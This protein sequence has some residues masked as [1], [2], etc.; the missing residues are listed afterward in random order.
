MARVLRTLAT[1]HR[2][3]AQV[4]CSLLLATALPTLAVSG[5][6]PCGEQ[7]A[8][9]FADLLAACD[10]DAGCAVTGTGG[11]AYGSDPQ[12]ASAFLTTSSSDG[13]LLHPNSSITVPVAESAAVLAKL[14]LLDIVVPIYGQANQ[15][16]VL[17][18]GQPWDSCV[19]Q[20]LAN[21]GSGATTAEEWKC[22]CPADIR[23]VELWT[24]DASV[25]QATIQL[26][27]ETCTG[28]QNVICGS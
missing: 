21:T 22:P 28:E 12:D 7:P 19:P 18:D 1:R 6:T 26:T 2:M 25:V 23:S 5:C 4:V 17:V 16:R 3:R 10:S 24:L 13:V 20:T 14:P 11:V 9:K 8:C 15:V 27:E